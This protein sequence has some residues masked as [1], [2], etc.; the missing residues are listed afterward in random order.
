MGQK[1][2]FVEFGFPKFGKHIFEHYEPF[3]Q[4]SITF[5]N[6]LNSL[7]S[8]AY[9]NVET[10]QKLVLNLGMLVGV[11][12]MELVTLVGNGFGQ[13]AMK[14]LRGLIENA[15][16]AEFLRL[17]PNRCADYLDWHWVEQHKLL[18]WA[19]E[20]N[21]PLFATISDESK[22]TIENNFN[23]VRTRFEYTNFDGKTKLRD[24]WCELNLADRAARTGFEE[25]YRL[26]MPHANQ[27]L[28]GT[29][30]GL[31][32]HFDL[33]QDSHRIAIPPSEDWC[34]EALIAGHETVLKTIETLSKTFSVDPEPSLDILVA[35][36]HSVWKLLHQAQQAAEPPQP[37]P[38]S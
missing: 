11:S 18:N 1:V 28:H 24:A 3:F 23:Q 26:V 16:N 25:T 9:D 12:M 33:E 20:R 13:G 17:E 10:W 32:R 14:I 5:Q 34:G 4:S 6:T 37:S 8:R 27:I 31:S 15:I 22:K 38:S 29:I 35:E 30:G 19:K 7:T 21:K 2:Q 36:F